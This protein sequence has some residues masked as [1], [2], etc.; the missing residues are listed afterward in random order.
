MNSSMKAGVW[1]KYI[2][3]SI[4]KNKSQ[5]L[6][7]VWF[8]SLNDYIMPYLHAIVLVGSCYCSVC[9][10]NGVLC[11]ILYL[12]CICVYVCAYRLEKWFPL[13]GE[14]AHS[15]KLFCMYDKR[16]KISKTK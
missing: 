3:S 9:H 13:R 16:F 8:L 6:A 14:R 1:A 10:N 5:L 2:E 15:L 11:T 12:V 4:A 7:T